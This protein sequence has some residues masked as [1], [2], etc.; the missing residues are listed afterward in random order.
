MLTD[1]Q[2]ENEARHVLSALM[3]AAVRL[4]GLTENVEACLG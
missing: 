4:R 1:Q 2:M 3:A